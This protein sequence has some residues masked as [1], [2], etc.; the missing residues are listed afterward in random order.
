MAAHVNAAATPIIA[1]ATALT[2]EG[3]GVAGVTPAGAQAADP[4]AAVPQA[5]VA[6]GVANSTPVLG[7]AA[8]GAAP[9]DQAQQAAMLATLAQSVSQMAQAFHGFNAS[10]GHLAQR[11]NRVDSDRSGEIKALQL[12][13][14]QIQENRVY[15]KQESFIKKIAEST[16]YCNLSS[17]KNAI[18]A[19]LRSKLYAERTLK[20]LEEA[21]V[22]LL[23]DF[24]L[25]N[26]SDAMRPLRKA[27]K[28]LNSIVQ[29]ADF[30]ELLARGTDKL[31][32]PGAAASKARSSIIGEAEDLYDNKTVEWDVFFPDFKN[33]LTTEVGEAQKCLRQGDQVNA[34]AAAASNKRGAVSG[35]GSAPK[36]HRK[37]N[38]YS[39]NKSGNSTNNGGKGNNGKNNQG[40]N[41]RRVKIVQANVN[42][43]DEVDDE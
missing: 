33:W 15:N 9:V 29:K 10:Q 13:I 36:K 24:P 3:G 11:V 30:N 8:V 35:G 7:R 6:E 22:L 39:N 43:G 34:L 4:Q 17:S 26:D 32:H 1:P 19:A 23:V 31:V 40:G 21:I 42:L 12:R 41:G 20:F 16:T 28:F 5:G 27:I 18:I 38:G 25:L 14:Q 37:S 2:A